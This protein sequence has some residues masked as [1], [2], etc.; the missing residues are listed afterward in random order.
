[1]QDLVGGFGSGGVFVL[2]GSGD[3]GGAICRSFARAG[4]PVALSYRSDAEAAA[5]LARGILSE[6]GDAAVFQLDAAD[7]QAIG[8]TL[9]KAAQ[10][11]NGLH[12]IVYAAG[13]AFN[14]EFFSNTD[15]S[16]WRQWVDG[17]L[18]AAI[19]LAQAAIP[20]LRKSHGAFLALTTYQANMI[21]VR[22]GVSAISKAAVD[23]M[24]AVMAKEEGRYGVRANSLR[25]GWVNTESNQKIFAELPNL[26]DEKQRSIPLGRLGQ[27]E[28]IGEAVVFLCSRRA[29]FITG[30]NL[31]ADGGESL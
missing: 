23:R 1:M 29:G 24:I 19:S 4:V 8:V 26:R 10:R 12:S 17:D 11:M 18:L 31:I 6:G 28:E 30:A 27:P 21:E 2:G 14:P 9:Q 16:T 5:L 7:R 3:L 20:H 15:L 13:P 22:G 25:C